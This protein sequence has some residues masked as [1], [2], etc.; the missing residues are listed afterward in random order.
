L[1]H[2]TKGLFSFFFLERTKKEKIQRERKKK[3]EQHHLIGQKTIDV[4][5]V[6]YYLTPKKTNKQTNK[7]A[8]RINNLIF[9]VHM[10]TH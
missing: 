5:N 4:H 7:F 8:L 3:S 10:N 2:K 1:I 6:S 9:I